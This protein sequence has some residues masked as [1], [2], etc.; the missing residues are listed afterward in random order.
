MVSCCFLDDAVRSKRFELCNCDESLHPTAEML[1]C[2]ILKNIVEHYSPVSYIY[3]LLGYVW[4]MVTDTCKSSIQANRA[5]IRQ[6]RREV[7]MEAHF[8]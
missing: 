1:Y 6:H 5:R 7:N 2:R 8:R 4:I 3:H